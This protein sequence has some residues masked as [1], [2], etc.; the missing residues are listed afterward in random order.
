MRQIKGQYSIKN[1]KLNNYRNRVWDEIEGLDAFPIK[2]VPREMKTKVDSL[3]ISTSMLR[4][5]LEFKDKKYQ[6]EIV[7]R[8][9]VLGNV[10]S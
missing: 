2:P 1:H 3:A 9:F 10:G 8:P 4:P 7:Y 5:H 6:I